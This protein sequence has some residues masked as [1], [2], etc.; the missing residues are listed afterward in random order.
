MTILM[1]KYTANPQAGDVGLG[2]DF[3][4]K[5]IAPNIINIILMYICILRASG[6]GGG[7]TIIARRTNLGNQALIVAAGG[8]GGGSNDGLPGGNMSGPLVGTKL[9]RRNGSSATGEAGKNIKYKRIVVTEV[10][11]VYNM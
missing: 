5:I 7:Y 8:G 4:G 1:M 9:D 11:S 2:V 3:V 10:Y 6:G